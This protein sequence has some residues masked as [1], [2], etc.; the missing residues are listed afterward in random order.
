MEAT[1]EITKEAIIDIENDRWCGINCP[2]LMYYKE[3]RCKLYDTPL[4]F[5]YD[6]EDIATGFIRCDECKWLNGK[7]I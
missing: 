6:E 4:D 5:D 7:K 2:Y 3:H 1:A